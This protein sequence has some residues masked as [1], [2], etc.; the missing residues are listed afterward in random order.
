MRIGGNRVIPVNVRVI[1]ATNRNLMDMVRKGTFRE[2]LYYRLNVLPLHIPCLRERR[3]DF[4]ILIDYFLKN[5]NKELVFN[6]EARNIL[7][8]YNWPGNIRELENFINYLMVIVE[9]NQVRPEHIPERIANVQAQRITGADESAAAPLIEEVKNIIFVL[10]HH[11]S[12]AD[13]EDI[14]DI[15]WMCS[16]RQE[17]IGRKML[18][19]MLP[20]PL[21]EAQIRG[22][23]SVLNRW[24]CITVGIKKQGSQITSLGIQVLQSIKEEQKHLADQ[25]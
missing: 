21:S 11:G 16:K 25:A 4:F 24:G 22:K 15:L 9:D 19:S 8:H 5:K 10:S 20:R 14:L 12:L 7:L 2:D 18:Q 3:E 6:E 1:A 23:L 17:R 13:Y